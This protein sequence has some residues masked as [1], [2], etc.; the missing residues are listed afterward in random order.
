MAARPLAATTAATTV[1]ASSFGYFTAYT[2]GSLRNR[3]REKTG[4]KRL[5]YL[6]DVRYNIISW[7]PLAIAALLIFF[8]PSDRIDGV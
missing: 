5:L 3:G 6:A 4:L 2:R 1:T 8:R 7:I